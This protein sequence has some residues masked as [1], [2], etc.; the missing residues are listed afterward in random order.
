MVVYMLSVKMIF[1]KWGKFE[2]NKIFYVCIFYVLWVVLYFRGFVRDS[3]QELLGV[4]S[5]YNKVLVYLC[6]EDI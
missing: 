6:W 3:S 5:I 2:I 1:S 4:L